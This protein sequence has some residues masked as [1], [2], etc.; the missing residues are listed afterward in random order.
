MKIRYLGHSCFEI[1]AGSGVKIITDPYQGVGYELPQGLQADIVTVSHGHFDHCFTAGVAHKTLLNT[2]ASYAQE[3]IEI[4]GI[5]SYHDEVQGAKRG[6]NILFKM[7]VDGLTLCH[8]GDIGEECTPS[9]VNEIGKVDILLLPVGGT[10]TVDGAG[11]MRY[12][13]ALQPK[14]LLP[15]HYRPTDG[16][17]DIAGIEPF[18]ALCKGKAV[19][20]VLDGV[21]EVDEDTQGIFYMH[22]VK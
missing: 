13:A 3:G 19:H 21:L 14:I 8:M 22:R 2:T 10:Y 17:L 6:K 9:L 12:A 4:Y 20:E 16:S 15:M 1:T 18:L 5:L 7:Q 11:A